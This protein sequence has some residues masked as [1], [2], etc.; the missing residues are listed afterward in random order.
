MTEKYLLNNGFK[1]YYSVTKNEEAYLEDHMFPPVGAQYVFVGCGIPDTFKLGI[2]ATPEEMFEK[3]PYEKGVYNVKALKNYYHYY[4]NYRNRDTENVFG[5]SG[6]Q[7]VHFFSCDYLD[8]GTE[9][10]M[11]AHTQK[12]NTNHLYRCGGKKGSLSSDYAIAFYY[13]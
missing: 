3:I 7:K 10:K 5:F 4:A 11:C 6:I 2:I 8:D 9:L 12:R 13:K 1:K